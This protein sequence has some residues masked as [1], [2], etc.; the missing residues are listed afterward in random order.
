MQ[1]DVAGPYSYGVKLQRGSRSY[2]FRVKL[3][4]I[5]NGEVL[6]LDSLT[7]RVWKTQ[8]DGS[9]DLEV[10]Q[11][12][13]FARAVQLF[14]KYAFEVN[15]KAVAEV[16]SKVPAEVKRTSVVECYCAVSEETE[17]TVEDFDLD[18]LADEDALVK[19]KLFCPSG[20]GAAYPEHFLNPATTEDE[21]KF[22]RA[23]GQV[24]FL[25]GQR[26]MAYTTR[27]RFGV[28]TELY[29]KL[30]SRV[31]GYS[32]KGSALAQDPERSWIGK[33]PYLHKKTAIN[34]VFGRA[35][36][37]EDGSPEGEEEG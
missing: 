3:G 35:V 22:R 7:N 13:Q 31:E 36:V 15:G 26:R 9:L 17:E 10:N 1:F 2:L 25:P 8:K 32:E 12:A 11:A 19:V 37:S 24:R 30:I 14:D 34:T 18:E 4:P 29:D 23:V 16:L 21:L 33:I 27:N 6:S 28:Y 20:D 5:P